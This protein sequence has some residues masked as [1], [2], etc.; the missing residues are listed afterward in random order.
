MSTRGPKILLVDDDPNV[1][2]AL[3]RSLRRSFEIRTATSGAEG[4]EILDR[5]SVV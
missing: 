3:A 1:L 4:L 5:K 2:E